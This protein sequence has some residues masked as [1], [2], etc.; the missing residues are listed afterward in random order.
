[1]TQSEFFLLLDELLE[2]S[3]GTLQGGESLEEYGW[4]SVAAIGFL[5]LADEYLGGAP[6]PAELARCVTGND[7]AA[8][9]PS[10]LANYPS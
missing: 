3:P 6:S 10:L 5:A 2:L 8:L 9:F 1:M 4:S 7:L